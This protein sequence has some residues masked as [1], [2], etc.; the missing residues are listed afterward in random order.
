MIFLLHMAL[1]CSLFCRLSI[2]WILTRVFT[3][4][5]GLDFMLLTLG[6]IVVEAVPEGA[7]GCH[8]SVGSCAA[9]SMRS[10][11]GYTVVFC[12]D[13]PLP[14]A[15]ALF[16][17]F[18]SASS[19]LCHILVRVGSAGDFLHSLIFRDRI[20]ALIGTVAA[21]CRHTRTHKA[22]RD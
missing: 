21:G 20:R 18:R 8:E 4:W 1:L 6:T 7:L 14:E 15:R 19:L 11:G 3:D 10:E 5:R 17:T 22:R 16:C 9:D 2:D 13:N 12:G